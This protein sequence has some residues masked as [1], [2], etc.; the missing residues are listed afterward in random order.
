[1][2]T[3][4][5]MGKWACPTCK[6]FTTGDAGEFHEP[7]Y[8]PIGDTCPRCGTKYID[9]FEEIDKLK[10]RIAE[11]NADLDWWDPSKA[12]HQDDEAT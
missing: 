7:S 9:P 12:P 4:H 5:G 2:T 6:T 1:M 10:A 3:Y 11:L 8:V